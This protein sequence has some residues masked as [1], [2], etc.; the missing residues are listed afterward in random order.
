MKEVILAGF[1]ENS[2]DKP[3]SGVSLFFSLAD[4]INAI[5]MCDSANH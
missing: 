4:K 1:Q 2:L 5:L 3:S